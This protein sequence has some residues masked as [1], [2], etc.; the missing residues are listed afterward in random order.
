MSDLIPLHLTWMRAGGRAERTIHDRR[1][2][3]EHA[4]ARLPYGLDCAHTDEWAA[5]LAGPPPSPGKRGWSDWTRDIYYRHGYAYYEWAVAG[6]WVTMNPLRGLTRPPEGDRLPRPVSDDDLAYALDQLPLMPWRMA[7]MLAA[8]AGLR[9]CEIVTIRR[10]DCSHELLTVRGKG[11]RLEQ[12]PMAPT[13]WEVVEPRP[14]GLLVVGAR[15]KP[16]TAQMLTQMQGNVWARIGLDVTLHRFR[17][18]C[19]TNVQRQTGDIRV[20]QKILRHKSTRSTEGYTLVSDTQ[21]HAAVAAL[22]FPVAPART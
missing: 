17:H 20:T 7:V 4:D 2:L 3:L 21:L 11:G 9:C 16:L 12:V 10:Q 14:P 15:G 18:W 1:R 22:P 5:Y 8:F 13:L 19:G 6:G